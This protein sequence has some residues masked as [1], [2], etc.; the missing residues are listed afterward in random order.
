[1]RIKFFLKPIIF[2]LFVAAFPLFFLSSCADISDAEATVARDTDIITAALDKSSLP[3]KPKDLDFIKIRDDIWLGDT[4]VRHQASGLLPSQFERSDGITLVSNKAVGFSEILKKIGDLTKLPIRYSEEVTTLLNSG[5]TSSTSTTTS[6][7]GSATSGIPE[8]GP[9]TMILSYNGPLSKLLDQVAVKFGVWWRYEY[10]EIYFYT[11]ETKTFTLYSLPSSHS[12]SSNLSSSNGSGGASID[13]SLEISLKSWDTVKETLTSMLKSDGKL[14][15][16]QT[17]G[18]ITVTTT[19]NNMREITRFINEQ[20]ER[21][22]RQVA[23]NIKLLQ[24]DLESTSKFGLDL[25]AAF[26]WP[27]AT[28]LTSTLDGPYSATDSTTGV[29]MAVV[30]ATGKH[31]EHWNGS[32]AIMDALAKQGDVSLLTT[33]TVTTLNNKPAP[34]Q[35]SKTQSYVRSITSTIRD[36]GSSKDVSIEPADMELGLTIDVLP[37][38]LDHGRVLLMFSMNLIELLNLDKF[39]SSDSVVQLPT[40]ETRGFSQEIAMRSGS[41]LVLTGFEK[42]QNKFDKTGM[43]QPDFQLLG[44]LNSSEKTRNVLVI[45]ITPEVLDSPLSPESRISGF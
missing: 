30:G 34:I 33:S 44:G 11:M 8:D 10:D 35:V 2:A 26:A 43:G 37:R 17:S 45:L 27:S 14:V 1:M 36:S 12:V 6:T 7:S 28:G 9:G 16:D 5:S 21:L 42:I 41:T 24:V 18:T 3:T 25:T 19:P 22:S 31:W 4:S 15:V 20:N 40:I 13:Q 39:E 38:I 29:T 32:T 23:I